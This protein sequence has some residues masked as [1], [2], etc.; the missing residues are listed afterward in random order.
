M[1]IELLCTGDEL[2]TGLTADTNS[3]YF[4][5]RLLNE[6]GERVRRI[7]VVPDVLDDIVQALLG[8]STRAD[9]VLVSGGLG[10]TADD[11]TAEAAAKARGVSL[12]EDAATVAWLRER[13]AQ[14][15]LELTPNNLRQARVP[16]G[17]EVVRNPVGAAPMFIL[18]LG[19]CTFCFVPG[20]PR[21]Y[22]AL[23]DQAVLPRLAQRLS[24]EPGRRFRAF[25]L[26]KTVGL[27]E[28]HL[29]QR[30]APLLVQHPD[31][32]FGFRTEAPENH[33]KLLATGSSPT[34]ARERLDAA[35]AAARALLTP[36]CFGAGDDTL[37]GV[38]GEALVR[39]QESVAVAE[40]C[41]GGLLSELFT[42]VEGASRYFIGGAVAYDER[43][44][45][46]WAGVPAETLERFG[47]VSRETALALARGVRQSAGTAWGLSVTGFAGPTGGTAE[48]PLGTV[49]L[50]LS[51]PAS[52]TLPSG[53]EC[54]RSVFGKGRGNVR[55][56]AAYAALDLLRKRL[57]QGAP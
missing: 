44:K 12:V 21:E 27:P 24:S 28:S 13:F 18:Q 20:V 7:Q 51:G 22:R 38:V 30:V 5:G 57:A 2:L 36:W 40:S 9:F 6:L 50:A 48:D 42:D 41:T 54:V 1:R 8:L 52:P 16:Q 53:E 10:P 49:Y 31:V 32:E 3:V 29:D 37:A 33:L 34:E 11:V 14:R 19:S 55:R 23:V 35:A 56:F 26:L 43:M 17:S 45:R 47:A 15:G 4:S 46:A 39:R 25:C